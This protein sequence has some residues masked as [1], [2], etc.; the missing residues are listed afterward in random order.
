MDR[1]PFFFLCVSSCFVCVCV[2]CPKISVWLTGFLQQPLAQ[3]SRVLFFLFLFLC[4][5]KCPHV[6]P[7]GQEAQ[8]VTTPSLHDFL[9]G[10]CSGVSLLG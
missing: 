3:R 5:A 6:I 8:I 10:Q 4:L 7:F 1:P 9:V 2:F